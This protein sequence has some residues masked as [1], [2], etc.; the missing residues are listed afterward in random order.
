MF[1]LTLTSHISC[2]LET[3][4]NFVDEQVGEKL[5]GVYLETFLQDGT[6]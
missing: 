5:F 2:V 6:S 3:Y 4:K 1:R